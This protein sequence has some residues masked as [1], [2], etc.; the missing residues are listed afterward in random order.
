M[1]TTRNVA[2][3][4]ALNWRSEQGTHCDRR[5]F[6]KVSLWR[7]Y[8]PGDLGERLYAAEV[9][10]TIAIDVPAGELVPAHDKTLVQRLKR[11]Q[12]RESPRPGLKVT[13]RA[14]RLYPGTFFDTNA[15][16]R[17]DNRPSR[18]LAVDDDV[19]E[20][21]FNH[22]FAR[23]AARIEAMIVADL[24]AATERGGRCNDIAQELTARGP[25]M[26]VPAPGQTVDFLAGD[27]F[28]HMDPRDDMQFYGEPRLV[29]H[30]DAAARARISE[31]YARFLKPGMQVLD[32]MSS[33]VSHLPDDI[34]DLTVTGL[35]LNERELAE[36][37]RLA[38]RIVHDLNREPRLPFADGRFDAVFCTVSVEYLTHPVEVFQNVAR[39]LKPGAPFVVTFSERWFPPKAIE[40]WGE[41]HPFERIGLVLDYFR[42][43]GGFDELGTESLRGLPRPEDDKYARQMTQSDPVYAVWGRRAG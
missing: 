9:G 20:V 30:I 11:A 1:N 2:L 3:E 4:V 34:P 27:P 17:G 19:M 24:G 6:E 18:I 32:L 28:A 38:E 13:P 21:D 31:I 26:Q 25:G 40:L 41:L 43:A 37:P 14:G 39:V 35:G 15:F 7:D 23:Y 16:F 22:P 12:F 29:H 8:F 33:W 42:R 36:N 5:H 10:E